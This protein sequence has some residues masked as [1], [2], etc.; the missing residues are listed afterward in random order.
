MDKM[1]KSIREAHE[2]IDKLRNDRTRVVNQRN[3]L[4]KE[5]YQA[6]QDLEEKRRIIKKLEKIPDDGE[7]RRR[8][9]TIIRSLIKYIRGDMHADI[10]SKEKYLQLLEPEQARSRESSASKGVLQRSALV[11]SPSP[12]ASNRPGS[13]RA[14]SA[15][16]QRSGVKELSSFFLPPVEVPESESTDQVSIHESQANSSSENTSM[17]DENL[18]SHYTTK[19]LIRAAVDLVEVKKRYGPPT[20]LG[21]GLKAEIDEDDIYQ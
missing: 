17:R 14:V 7:T 16:S 18:M 19:E 6:H 3:E 1:Q 8:D 4:Q 15:T 11:R 20:K 9:E 12:V 5:V 10:E 21:F 13:D 2:V